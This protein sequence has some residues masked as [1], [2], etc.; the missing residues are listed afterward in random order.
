MEY[1]EDIIK[2]SELVERI[3]GIAEGGSEGMESVEGDREG[4]GDG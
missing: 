4:E 1:V 2:L 3:D